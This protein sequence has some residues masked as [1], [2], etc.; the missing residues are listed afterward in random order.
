MTPF[1]MSLLSK[2]MTVALFHRR[3]LSNATQRSAEVLGDA[4]HSSSMTAHSAS[5][6]ENA[7]AVS[8]CGPPRFFDF[9]LMS[10]SCQ[11]TFT[12]VNR[13]VY[14]CKHRDAAQGAC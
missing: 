12:S 3:V 4:A 7:S 11:K 2:V 10:A 1:A 14:N 6:M 9:P 8:G 13:K 5:E